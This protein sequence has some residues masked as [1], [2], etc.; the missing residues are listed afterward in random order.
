MVSLNYLNLLLHL[1]TCTFVSVVSKLIECVLRVCV[2]EE[3]QQL[4]S[5]TVMHYYVAN[6]WRPDNPFISYPQSTVLKVFHTLMKVHFI[7]QY[8]WQLVST[9]K[10]VQCTIDI[11]SE[12]VCREG[13]AAGVIMKLGEYYTNF[14][15]GGSMHG[16]RIPKSACIYTCHTLTTLTLKQT[17]YM[18]WM[19]QVSQGKC[20]YQEGQLL[21]LDDTIWS[22]WS[23]TDLAAT[24]HF[25]CRPNNRH[26]KTK[27]CS[28]HAILHHSGHAVTWLK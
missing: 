26:T 5:H 3:A 15:L 4:L 12:C 14:V 20:F 16:H 18:F 7:T 10:Y 28:S 13:H 25:W 1:R 6:Y 23:T 9:L 21:F 27:K 17:I 11:G 8:L 24:L 2:K 19:L 22:Q